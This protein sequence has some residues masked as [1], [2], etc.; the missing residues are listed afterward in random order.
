MLSRAP[1]N[2]SYWG[3]DDITTAHHQV[4]FITCI[5]LLFC[6]FV[7]PSS[8]LFR[9]FSSFCFVPHSHS[10]SGTQHIRFRMCVHV[11]LV[12]LQPRFKRIIVVILWHVFVHFFLLLHIGLENSLETCLNYLYNEETPRC[13]FICAFFGIQILNNGATCLWLCTIVWSPSPLDYNK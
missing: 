7:L 2:T 5:Y 10:Q 9:H 8:L 13:E 12:I 11:P 6:M 3:K 4:P 1:C